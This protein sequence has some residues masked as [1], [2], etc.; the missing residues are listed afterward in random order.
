MTSIGP[1]A[2][3]ARESNR[4]GASGRFGAQPPPPPPAAASSRLKRLRAVAVRE[5]SAAAAAGEAMVQAIERYAEAGGDPHE[6]QEAVAQAVGS[7]TGISD[8]LSS[9]AEMIAGHLVEDAAAGQ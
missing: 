6:V 9:E 1:A 5:A 4:D 3:A 2:A 7:G 8:F